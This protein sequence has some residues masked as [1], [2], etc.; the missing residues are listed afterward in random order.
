MDLRSQFEGW[1]FWGWIVSGLLVVTCGVVWLTWLL[2]FFSG[3]EKCVGR[4][5]LIA[6]GAFVAA[7]V[8]FVLLLPDLHY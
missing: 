5:L 1:F 2:A 7:A 3:N 4:K 6:T 8:L